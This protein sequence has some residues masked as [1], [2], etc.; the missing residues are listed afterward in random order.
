MEFSLKYHRY[1]VYSSVYRK[2][3]TDVLLEI[4]KCNYC[5]YSTNKNFVLRENCDKKAAKAL[6]QMYRRPYFI[7]HRY[8]VD[9]TDS[10]WVLISSNF[11]GKVYKE[12]SN[13]QTLRT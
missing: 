9:F 5:N 11:K 4:D 8:M 1:T 13:I 7:P 12:V 10:N 6:R 2:F 3:V